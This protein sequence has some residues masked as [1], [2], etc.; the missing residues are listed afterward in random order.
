LIVAVNNSGVPLL[1][2]H[3]A[4]GTVGVEEITFQVPQ[5]VAPSDGVPVQLGV[6]LGRRTV[7]S[8][9]SSLPVR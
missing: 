7:Y 2:A 4:E 3:Y 9:T 1:S 5:N 8:N 6:V